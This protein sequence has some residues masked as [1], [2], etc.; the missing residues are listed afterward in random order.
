MVMELFPD[1]IAVQSG[2]YADRR[3]EGCREAVTAARH[4]AVRIPRPMAVTGVA[5]S[6]PTL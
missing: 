6:V 5:V 1:G 3:A 2:R 4:V